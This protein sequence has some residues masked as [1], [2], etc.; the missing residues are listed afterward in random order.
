MTTVKLSL[1]ICPTC[2]S[3]RIRPVRRDIASNRGGKPYVAH[4]IEIEEC[5]DCG[6][7][8]FSPDALNEIAARQPRA[9]KVKAKRKS[10]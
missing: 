6:E 4:D 8:L 9:G 5:P 7:R 3:S 10:M 1:A 2:E